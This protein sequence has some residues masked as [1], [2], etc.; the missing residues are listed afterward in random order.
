MKEVAT[1][2]GPDDTVALLQEDIEHVAVLGFVNFVA[3][4]E[5]C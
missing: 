2:S 3:V 5:D 4:L 1:L